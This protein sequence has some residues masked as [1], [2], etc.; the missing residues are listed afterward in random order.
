[1][2]GYEDLVSSGHGSFSQGQRAHHMP[3]T[4]RPTTVTTQE[5][6]HQPA[7]SGFWAT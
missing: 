4:Q 3:D 6:A 7:S 1:M 2:S 5:N